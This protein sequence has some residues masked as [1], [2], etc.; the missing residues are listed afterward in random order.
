MEINRTEKTTIV[1]TKNIDIIPAS[2][3]GELKMSIGRRSQ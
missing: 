2:V 3:V 1:V